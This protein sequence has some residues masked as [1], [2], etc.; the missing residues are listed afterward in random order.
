[1]SIFLSQLARYVARKAASDPEIRAKA[2][3]A[4]S[5]AV[6]QAKKIAKEDDRARAAGKAVRQALDRLQSPKNHDD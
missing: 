6:Y 3:K 2:I 5:G 1:M 4:A